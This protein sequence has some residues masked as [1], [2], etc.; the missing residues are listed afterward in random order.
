LLR[1]NTVQGAL[2]LLRQGGHGSFFW[3]KCVN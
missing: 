3:K 1:L 2:A